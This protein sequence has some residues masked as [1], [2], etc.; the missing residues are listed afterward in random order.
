M[1]L[2]AFGCEP[3]HLT[4]S[5][6]QKATRTLTVAPTVSTIYFAVCQVPGKEACSDFVEL[7]VM[8]PACEYFTI[9]ASETE[10]KQGDQV[11]L[12]AQGCNGQLAWNN[13]LG[14]APA[15]SIFPTTT[16]SFTARCTMG[17]LSCQRTVTIKVRCTIVLKI[18][19][20]YEG[21]LWGLLADKKVKLEATCTT[22]PLL[23]NGEKLQGDIFGTKIFDGKDDLTLVASC[24]EGADACTQTVQV[25]AVTRACRD[26]AV[27]GTEDLTTLTLTA[28]GCREGN[29]VTWN[30]GL[31][32]G[33]ITLPLP[34]E[35][36]VFKAVCGRNG[37]ENYYTYERK[38]T[39][40]LFH[41]QQ[42]PGN[43][44]PV[45]LWPV[46]CKGT[47]SWESTPASSLKTDV[48]KNLI[49]DSAPT[50]TTVYTATCITKEHQVAQRS[51]TL[52]IPLLCLSLNAPQSVAKG[53]TAALTAIGCL[54]TV[55]WKSS[56]N[57][58]GIGLSPE[59]W[60][61][62]MTPLGTG[63]VL[64][65]LPLVNTI[66]VASCDNPGCLARHIVQ[67]EPCSFTATATQTTLKAGEETI[68]IAQ[69]CPNGTV[70]WQDAAG[71]LLGWGEELTLHPV[72]NLKIKAVCDISKCESSLSINVPLGKPN[73]IIC[74]NLILLADPDRPIFKG[75]STTVK[76]TASGC[77]GGIVTWNG[78]LLPADTPTSY[79]DHT[80]TVVG[81]QQAATYT[82]V[83]TKTALPPVSAVIDIK[84]EIRF[85]LKAAP[86]AVEVGKTTTLTA[87]GCIGGTIVWKN[88]TA[89]CTGSPCTINSPVITA[90]A[91]FEATCLINGQTITK[92]VNVSL[93]NSYGSVVYQ[94]V[95][96]SFWAS[97]SAPIQASYPLPSGVKITLQ[98]GGCEQRTVKWKAEDAEGNLRT[99]TALEDR[100]ATSTTYTASCETNGVVCAQKQFLVEVHQ[101][102]CQ[103]FEV[104]V[105]PQS[106]SGQLGGAESGNIS[107][108]AEYNGTFL[109]QATGCISKDKPGFE[110]LKVDYYPIAGAPAQSVLNNG[111]FYAQ[112][113]SRVE[114][115][116]IANPITYP[117]E[118]CKYTLYFEKT[119]IRRE[120]NSNARI[121][122]I[123]NSESTKAADADRATAA[124]GCTAGVALKNL[125]A[126]FFATLLCNNINAFYDEYGQ[127]SA[128]KTATFLATAEDQLR[129]DPAF[130]SYQPE[131]PEDFSDIIDQLEALEGN[132]EG[133][134]EIAQNLTAEIKGTMPVDA[135]NE[136]A[137]KS[138]AAV[139]AAAREEL[140]TEDHVQ[141]PA[142]IK[143]TTNTTEN[144]CI[145]MAVLIYTLKS[146]I[147]YKHN[148]QLHDLPENCLTTQE[149]NVIVNP[150]I[151]EMT[152]P[153]VKV[154]FSESFQADGLTVTTP[155][156]VALV[157]PNDSKRVVIMR[158]SLPLLVFALDT[159][160]NAKRLA[161]YFGVAPAPVVTN[162][163]FPITGEQLKEIFPKTEQSRCNEVAEL[164]NKYSDKFEINTPLRMA[165]FLGQIGVET[166]GLKHTK[167]IPCYREKAIRGN[168]GSSKYC[169]LYE[170]F[171]CVDLD[172]CAT[173][174]AYVKCDGGVPTTKEEI[175]K[176]YIC[177]A[178]LFDYVYS[179]SARK[180]HSR[181]D[182]GNGPPS[183]KDGST[184][185]GRGFIQLTGKSNYKDLSDAWNKDPENTDN[186][187]YFHKQ[188]SEGGHIDELETDLD[189]AMKASMYYW[190]L[191]QCNSEADDDNTAEVTRKV[192]GSKDKDE[193]KNRGDIKDN[194]I[195]VLKK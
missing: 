69:G 73:P 132:C 190:Q 96:S 141:K 42:K 26:F 20:I 133:V 27:S 148:L 172:A 18:T 193:V 125:M 10:I 156:L 177:S 40:E 81:L 91:G 176:K 9:N 70:V 65:D 71:A 182:L 24:G 115:T 5:T 107:V 13:G 94:P 11:M 184:F 76:L 105:M 98:Q 103:D 149:S 82:A 121:G 84:A 110:Q 127:F 23:L 25:K 106:S 134:A 152:L 87:E 178:A 47:V 99:L 112:L 146:S 194:A 187:K 12:T 16:T 167:E 153:L 186:K 55:T 113:N 6:G 139:E 180:K 43:G 93:K 191:R 138:Y 74:E 163:T 130:S 164:I 2:F 86:E 100:P 168:F 108:I 118:V 157:D 61:K 189:V 57:T 48:N 32:G 185:L 68:L 124:S 159:E 8:P 151:N 165:H 140:E 34:K 36:T 58:T 64:T 162:A 15:I 88:P 174:K 80:I 158:G 195:K 128:E 175:K 136:A 101:P 37:C 63:Q 39:N 28:T 54:G 7:K 92:S 122:D 19:P 31:S 1:T 166:G 14:S 161:D 179:C 150:A 114:I 129:N 181:Y 67:V 143:L 137:A 142:S 169:D 145:P 117:G 173:E 4:W 144:K 51:Y 56:T 83:C 154:R 111:R 52:E 72:K 62:S 123:A 38:N 135:Y 53:Q 131:F 59:G 22:G 85:T 66:Y 170:G 41:I 119:G 188:T 44:Y 29:S 109:I 75:E 78:P 89:S 126:D 116:C 90:P 35:S 79:P 120:N 192:K 102:S 155:T 21:S 77:T 60:E 97:Y 160:E 17:S 95:C 147:L 49:I 104:F 3:Q 46:N 50:Y 171:D 33:T 45:T 183:S 30:N